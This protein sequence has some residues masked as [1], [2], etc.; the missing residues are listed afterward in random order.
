MPAQ[1]WHRPGLPPQSWGTNAQ[2]HTTSLQIT[3][4]LQQPY[5]H[6]Q[7]SPVGQHT[8]DLDQ[9]LVPDAPLWLSMHESMCTEDRDINKAQLFGTAIWESSTKPACPRLFIARNKMWGQKRGWLQGPS[10]PC[11]PQHRAAGH[12]DGERLGTRGQGT[13]RSAARSPLVPARSAPLGKLP[14]T[15]FAAAA[16]VG[17]G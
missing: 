6:P 15:S 14:S 3:P 17:S 12:R 8:V 11:D 16:F 5:Q 1:K 4:R 10:H 13:C 2:H 9:L 7:T